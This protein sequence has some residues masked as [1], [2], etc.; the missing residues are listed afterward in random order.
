LEG[1]RRITL[2]FEE[3]LSSM[4]VVAYTVYTLSFSFV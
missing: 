2:A 4:G 1:L 3:E